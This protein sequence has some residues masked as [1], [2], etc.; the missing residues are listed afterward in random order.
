M[1]EDYLLE[2]IE[3][4]EDEIQIL[5][6]DMRKAYQYSKDDPKGALYKTRIITEKIVKEMYDKEMNEPPPKQAMLGDDLNE[7]DPKNR[8]GVRKV[9]FLKKIDAPVKLQLIYLQKMG[10]FGS[11]DQ[12][13]QDQQLQPRQ[14]IST[15]NT[16]CDVIEWFIEKYGSDKEN[17][18]AGSTNI[19]NSQISTN[20]NK[21][22]LAKVTNIKTTIN[23]DVVG[24]VNL[25]PGNQV[26]NT[27]YKKR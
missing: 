8:N 4:L 6:G 18:K 15:L 10:N 16:L 11:H 19:Q 20:K 26:V 9:D 24:N 2:Q 3:K 22:I 17:G 7:A 25:G 13:E 1:L 21:Q 5:K 27:Q 14:V 12:K 23:G